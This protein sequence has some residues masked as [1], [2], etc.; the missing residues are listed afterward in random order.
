MFIDFDIVRGKGQ[1]LRRIDT[2]P[3]GQYSFDVSPDGRLLAIEK[4]GEPEG[5]IR[6]LPLREGRAQDVK[7]KGWGRLNS[8]DWTADGKGFLA[9][10]QT[11]TGATLLHIDLSG[12]ARPLWS[13]RTGNVALGAPSPDGK[14]VAIL[15]STA[16]SNVW[17]IENF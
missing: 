13:E 7:V 9:S 4:A 8:L 2:D 15:G 14:K 11:G 10:S 6:I 5:L 3:A 16:V 1:E 17:M 12:N